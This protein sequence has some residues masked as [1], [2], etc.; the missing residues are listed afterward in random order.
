ML[1]WATVLPPLS[2]NGLMFCLALSGARL[3]MI[4]IEMAF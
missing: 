2:I 3:L 1:V 4:W